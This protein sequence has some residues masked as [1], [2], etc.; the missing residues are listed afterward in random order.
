MVC[1]LM[2]PWLES[3]A[4]SNA[5]ARCFCA[6]FI[7]RSGTPLRSSTGMKRQLS[8]SASSNGNCVFTRCS[9]ESEFKYALAASDMSAGVLIRS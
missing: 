7:S 2:M 8:R 3:A 6:E 4:E 9:G 1:A 5:S